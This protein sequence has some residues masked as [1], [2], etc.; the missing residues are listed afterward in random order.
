MKE[1]ILDIMVEI[2]GV[3]EIKEDLDIELFE[4]GIF[5]S[6]AIVEFLIELEKQLGLKIEPTE[7]EREDIET[8]NKAIE[9]IT[10]RS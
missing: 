7:I 4:E 5:D 2:T 8:P 6:L 10:K 3:D 1:K 9:F